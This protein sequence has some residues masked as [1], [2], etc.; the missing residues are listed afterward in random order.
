MRRQKEL[1]E[2]ENERLRR[3]LEGGRPKEAVTIEQATRASEKIIDQLN[4][5]L[6]ISQESQRDAEDHA[7]RLLLEI[8]ELAQKNE[9]LKAE[10]NEIGN[11]ATVL[12]QERI[13]AVE[14]AQNSLND[15]NV[16]KLTTKN[17]ELED[18]LESALR[19]R[20][21]LEVKLFTMQ[22]I[23]FRVYLL[24]NFYMH[25]CHFRTEIS[26]SV[27]KKACQVYIKF[28]YK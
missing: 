20:Y 17:R 14:K 8:E 16:Q 18:N 28:N 2:S 5:Q 22:C 9:K 19:S 15:L 24:Y 11:M 7:A 4:L 13:Q 23:L 26:K 6:E 25:L 10:M 3:Q 1:V 21:D 12:E 27:V